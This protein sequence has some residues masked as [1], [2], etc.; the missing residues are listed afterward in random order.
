MQARE[1]TDNVWILETSTN[2]KIGII[3]YNIESS[4]YSVISTDIDIKFS[5]IGRAHV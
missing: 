3:N 1:I 4:E 5:K 2:E